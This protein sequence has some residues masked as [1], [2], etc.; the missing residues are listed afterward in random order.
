M[1]AIRPCIIAKLGY[2]FGY[3]IF[4]NI[5]R[6]CV[7]V[8]TCAQR[9]GGISGPNIEKENSQRALRLQFFVTLLESSMGMFKGFNVMTFCDECIICDFCSQKVC[10][11]AAQVNDTLRLSKITAITPKSISDHL[12]LWTLWRFKCPLALECSSLQLIILSY[13]FK[14]TLLTLHPGQVNYSRLKQFWHC[15]WNSL[16]HRCS[17][18]QS[19]FLVDFRRGYSIAK[20][21][22]H[23][24]QL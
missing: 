8:C 9:C 11:K 12:N 5:A 14:M 2:K 13:I 24:G 4:Y 7:C 1:H 19:A 3:S 20:E 16:S 10:W 17:D 22:K 15:T 6:A 21:R 18:L 23:L